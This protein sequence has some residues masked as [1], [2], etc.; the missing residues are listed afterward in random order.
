MRHCALALGENPWARLESEPVE[1]ECLWD[2]WH[3]RVLVRIRGAHSRKFPRKSLQLDFPQEPMPDAPPEGHTVRRVHLNA[4]Y[5]DPTRMRSALSFELFRRVGVP[6]PVCRH[7][8]LTVSGAFAGLYVALESVDA[9]FCRR[10]G[11]PPGAIYYAVNRNANFG[12]ISPFTRTVKEPLHRGYQAVDRADMKP[13]SRMVMDLNLASDAAFPAVVERWFEVEE[14]LRWLMVAVFVGNR[15]GF[16][17]NYALYRHPGTGRFWVIPWDYDATWGIDIHGRPARLDR[18]PVT[19]WNKLSYRLMA[20]PRY[21]RL[22]RSLFQQTLDGPLSPPS[23]I[24]LIDAMS[25]EVA[26]VIAK[27][28][29][30]WGQDRSFDA[31]VANLKDWAIRRRQLLLEELASL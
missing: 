21:R 5:V 6:A 29:C 14:Y 4:D 26:P 2:G 1:G 8:E 18:V 13:L 25:E 27:E 20:L 28:Q 19:G 30:L 12:L 23:V 16:V 11:W 3:G 31:E 10:R 9:D 22:Y 17:H 7:T 15:D 24:P